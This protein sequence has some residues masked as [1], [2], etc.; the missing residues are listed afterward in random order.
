M[1]SW[2][3]AR[4]GQRSGDVTGLAA[5]LERAAVTLPQAAVADIA[6]RLPRRAGR[7]GTV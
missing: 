6:G 4:G 1:V 2:S 3:T 7:R 5:I